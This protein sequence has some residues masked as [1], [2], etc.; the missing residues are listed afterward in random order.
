MT[1]RLLA[2][3]TIFLAAIV[4]AAPLA[5]QEEP[6]LLEARVNGAIDRGAASLVKRQAPDGSWQKDDPVH[7]L[8]RTA[9]A[10]Y[11]L[12][13]AGYPRSHPA[14]VQ[15][16]AFLGGGEGYVSGVTPR[17]TY[18]A[19]C[20]AL[21]LN[22]LGAGHA[23]TL[24]RVCDWLVERFDAG[25]RLWGYPDGPVDLSNT[26][27]AVL[28]LKAG[29]RHGYRAP[30]ATGKRL[31]DS[32]LRLLAEGGAI[33]HRGGA[34]VRATMTRAGLLVLRFAHEALGI[35]RPPRQVREAEERAKVWLEAND[36]VDRN[37]F[38]RGW[39]ASSCDCYPYGLSAT[40]CSR[41]SRRSRA[42]TGTG[43]ERR[44]SWRGRPRTGPGATSRRRASRSSSCGA[45]R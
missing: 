19:V 17:S 41:G 16:L 2:A 23:R 11:T 44:P 37:P 39:T 35:A 6:L 33:R 21:L 32:V 15:A 31:V 14:I 26:R 13:H 30:E 38:G 36:S 18:E 42:T 40:P 29:E 22:A 20:L 34:V 43:R 3:V 24:H 25:Q 1:G 7:P 5:A 27:F 45:P 4:H 12:L 28:A 8:G 9:L 10:V